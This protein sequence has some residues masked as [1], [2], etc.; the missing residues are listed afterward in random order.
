MMLSVQPNRP[1]NSTLKFIFG[2]LICKPFKYLPTVPTILV[3]CYSHH[4]LHILKLP[5]ISELPPT[6]GTAVPTFVGLR[7]G[8]RTTTPETWTH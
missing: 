6:D 4:I 3:F 2:G 8:P 5:Q 1:T 7:S